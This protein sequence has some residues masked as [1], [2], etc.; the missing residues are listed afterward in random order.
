MKLIVTQS[1]ISLFINNTEL[2]LTF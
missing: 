2:V 1:N